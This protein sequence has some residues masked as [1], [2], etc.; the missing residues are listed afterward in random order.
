M[1]IC[2]DSDACFS[3]TFLIN[4]R[5]KTKKQQRKTGHG[6]TIIIRNRTSLVD[7]QCSPDVFVRNVHVIDNSDRLCAQDS[8]A[9]IP[10]SDLTV[11][12]VFHV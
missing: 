10:K 9:R 5:V 11:F 6:E 7:G 3:T 12:F 4:A 1:R 2:S 8:P